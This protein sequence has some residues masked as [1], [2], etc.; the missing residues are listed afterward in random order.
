MKPTIFK[1]FSVFETINN[2]Y[3]KSEKI[4]VSNSNRAMFEILTAICILNPEF[5]AHILDGG[6]KKRY[7]L[8]NTSF[9]TD[10]KHIILNNNTKFK[11]GKWNAE[12]E[13]WETDDEIS[14]IHYVFNENTEFDIEK[15]WSILTKSD[16]LAKAILQELKIEKI[17]K[18]Y[19]TGL[20]VYSNGCEN[21]VIEFGSDQKMICIKNI[22]GNSF[23]KSANDVL[24]DLFEHSIDLY[25]EKLLPIWDTLTKKWLKLIYDHSIIDFQ[26]YILEWLDVIKIEEIDYKTYS[27]LKHPGKH[28]Q[29]LGKHIPELNKNITY[30]KDLCQEIFDEPNFMIERDLFMKEWNESK[31]ILLNSKIIEYS[32]IEE[33][34]KIGNDGLY[35]VVD[36]L[37][38]R[39]SSGKF[40]NSILNLLLD[41]V[42]NTDGKDIYFFSENAKNWTIIPSKK[43]ILEDDNIQALYRYHAELGD[44]DSN[45][46]L[47][48]WIGRNEI[49]MIQKM[50]VG[51]MQFDWFGEM[52]NNLKCKLSFDYDI[53]EI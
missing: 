17:D 19:W 9:M 1:D 26:K 20:D 34:K 46:E 33:L 16:K 50:L 11:I 27:G 47:D 48:I 37:K 25:D 28:N 45:F 39:A 15:N 3:T 36:S 23:T 21:I 10:V 18:V 35:Y 42:L 30:L 6:F 2:T 38:Y 13:K 40:K 52:S 4:I 53:K 5:L 51:K 12:A 22:F 8:D 32:F 41:K 49:N 29:K 31:D 43:A 7:T 44:A 24:S 14:K